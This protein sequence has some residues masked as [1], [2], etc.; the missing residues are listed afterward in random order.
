M[1]D[2]LTAANISAGVFYHYFPSKDA[3]IAAVADE[4]LAEI[5]SAHT[6]AKAPPLKSLGEFVRI[7]VTDIERV[8]QDSGAATLAI[9]LWSEALRNP[10]MA[11]VAATSV[12][13]VMD[14]LTTKVKALQ[15]AGHLSPHPAPRQVAA[16]LLAIVHGFM[17]QRALVKTDAK[18]YCKALK[19]LAL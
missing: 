7:I 8:D 14:W 16:I 5:S 10:D 9:Q 17:V 3:I 1:Q 15:H 18:A 11:R 12:S 6:G 2:L 4:V 13:K 19:D